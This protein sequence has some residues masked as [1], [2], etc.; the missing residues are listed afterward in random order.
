MT[1]LGKSFIVGADTFYL[2]NF[3]SI[4]KRSLIQDNVEQRN[5]FPVAVVRISDHEVLLAFQSMYQ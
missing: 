2:V 1:S 4:E 3:V 5:D